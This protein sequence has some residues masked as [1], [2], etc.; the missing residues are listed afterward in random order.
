MRENKTIF[1]HGANVLVTFGFSM[2]VLVFF[3]KVFGEDG[4]EI[5]TMFRLGS[6]GI[7]LETMMEYLVVIILIEILRTLF[8][9][10]KVLKGR[11]VTVRV[12]GMLISV[13]LLVAVFI[14]IFGWFPVNMLL[15]WVMFFICFGICF[16]LGLGVSSFKE[17]LENKK[18]EEGLARLKKELE[19]ENR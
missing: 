11:S 9:S 3:C 14:T 17:K 10:D 15:P 16:G 6:S 4:K 12:A 5:S 8:F 19:D 2:I 7:A 13:I 1:E 18:M